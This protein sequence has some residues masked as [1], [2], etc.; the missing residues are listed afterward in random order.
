MA[1]RQ[2]DSAGIL[3]AADVW[4]IIKGQ[5]FGTEVRIPPGPIPV[6]AVAPAAL[7]SASPRRPARIWIGHA[8]VYVEI[9]GLR[10]LIDPIFSEYASPFE[11]GPR[12]FHPPP[13][14]L[15]DLPRIDAVLITH[16]HYDHL[17]M[18]TIQHLASHGSAFFVPLGIG[19]HLQKWGVPA[20][21]VHELEWWQEH[22]LQGVRLVSTPSRHYS[23]RG[24]TDQRAT[25]WTSWSVIGARPRFYVSGDSGYSDHFRAIGERFG[26][27]T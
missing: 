21:Q 19:A 3:P 20:A 25:L 14:A 12:R 15:D 23:G 7:K 22:S 16:D 11:L 6:L 4:S 10:M 24:L 18:R 2:R 27:S 1:V 9:D 17:D 8:S 13:I 5:F 26:R